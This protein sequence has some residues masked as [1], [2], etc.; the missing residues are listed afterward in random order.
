[1]KQ[2]RLAHEVGRDCAGDQAGLEVLVALRG[3]ADQRQPRADP[4]PAAGEYV[5]FDVGRYH[6]S[7]RLSGA[8]SVVVSCGEIDEQGQP[9][10]PV[11]VP[12]RRVVQAEDVRARAEPTGRVAQARELTAQ[13]AGDDVVMETARDVRASQSNGAHGIRSQPIPRRVSS[14]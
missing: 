12:A 3:P 9:A 11:V 13:E 8:S 2:Q 10:A 7:S 14:D 1:M 4:R 5:P 6:A